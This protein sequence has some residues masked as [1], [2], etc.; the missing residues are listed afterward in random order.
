MRILFLSKQKPFSQDAAELVTKHFPKSIVIFGERNQPFPDYLLKEE[1]DYVIS[2][3]SPWIVPQEMLERTK[4][5]AINFHPGSPAYPGIGCT[6]FAIY[7][8]EKEF[9]ITVHHMKASVDTG[10]IILVEKFPIFPNDSVFSLTQ[11]CYAFIYVAFTKIFDCILNDKSLPQSK[12]VWLRKPYKRQ[13]LDDLC[14]L[15]RLM[16]KEEIYRRERAVTYPGM[17][18]AYFKD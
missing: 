6:N 18:G 16:S 10:D 12:E 3:I 1:F 7:N 17:P 13:E 15:S 9:G 8:N 11:R 4:K 5:A 2:Y 14:V